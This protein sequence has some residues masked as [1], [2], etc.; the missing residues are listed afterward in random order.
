MNTLSR[1]LHNVCLS[2]RDAL[3]K[4]TE[5]EEI[6]L[7]LETMCNDVVSA[8]SKESTEVDT[9]EIY[10]KTKE[11][12]EDHSYSW[13]FTEIRARGSIIGAE[14][15]HSK[16]SAVYEAK[17]KTLSDAV[18][19]ILESL[20]V[21]HNDPDM[22]APA[23]AEELLVFYRP[24]VATNKA[25]PSNEPASDSECPYHS[26]HKEGVSCPVCGKE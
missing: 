8:L 5:P 26:E 15:A 23:I 20:E 4:A 6:M 9:D 19:N 12:P 17:L 25:I 13:T 1:R 18:E 24:L 10:T 11:L 22:D 16:L 3:A 21:I 14:H 2:Y 7:I